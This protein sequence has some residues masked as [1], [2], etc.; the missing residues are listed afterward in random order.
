MKNKDS[1]KEIE[2]LKNEYQK[3]R[4]SFILLVITLFTVISIYAIIRN[5]NPDLVIV[6]LI[7]VFS[8][9][10]SYGFKLGLFYSVKTGLIYKEKIVNK[11]LKEN[12]K[13][14]E[15]NPWEGI[16]KKE[17]DATNM[18]NMGTNFHS[19]DL[20][21]GNFNNY[22]FV[23]SEVWIYNKKMRENREEIETLFKGQWFILDL[24]DKKVS[25]VQICDKF[26]FNTAMDS[27]FNSPNYNKVE[28]EDIEF[29][30]KFNVYAQSTLDAFKVLTPDMMLKIKQLKSKFECELLLCFIDNKLHIGIN[31]DK[32]IFE[33]DDDKIEKKYIEEKIINEMNNI[34]NFIENLDI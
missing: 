20:I 5:M 30:S 13:A 33:F 26:F 9:I 19:R 15:Y 29:N 10:A 14:I 3:Q 6:I 24:K 12:F 4:K 2:K 16:E 23:F 31:N 22:D 1:Y 8:C 21:K 27:I 32:D 11:V 7:I 34:K 28:L 17:I 25:N 18:I